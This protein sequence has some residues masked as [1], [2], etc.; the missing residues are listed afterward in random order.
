MKTWRWQF[1]KKYKVAVCISGLMRYWKTTS[2]LFEYWN[3]LYDDI[4]FYFFI[5]TWK[6][7]KVF[8]HKEELGDQEI[9]DFSKYKFLTSFRKIDSNKILYKQIL[10][11]YPK[12]GPAPFW[13]YGI[14]KVQE[15]RRE[16]ELK[17][18]M[19]FDGIIQTRSDVFLMKHD[20]DIVRL[21]FVSDS[22]PPIHP[23]LFF[24]P[25]GTSVVHDRFFMNCDYFGFA[26]RLAMDKYAEMYND[27]YVNEIN[28]AKKVHEI[29]AQQLIDNKIYNYNLRFKC[30]IIRPNNIPPYGKL[31]FPTPEQLEYLFQYRGM[32]FTL[33]MNR[34]QRLKYFCEN[35]KD[36]IK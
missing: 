12:V 4:E 14:Y 30:Y 11:K 32:N 27:C 24:S 25:A 1:M 18:N 17:N 3:N 8:I 26:H 23:K 13:T 7:D 2:K 36:N 6:N 15:L 9:F 10:K 29:G 31:G 21:L 34:V 19:K 35:W 28:V 22:G 20:L 5:L 16:Y 33:N